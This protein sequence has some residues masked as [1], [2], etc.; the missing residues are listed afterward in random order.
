MVTKRQFV[1]D[2]G[3]IIWLD[4]NPIRGHEQGGR[5]PALV[6]STREYNVIS[7]LAI[8]C[9]ATS[10]VKGYPFEVQFKIKNIDGVILADHIRNVDWIQRHADKVGTVSEAVVTEVQEY[11]KKLVLE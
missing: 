4:F 8:V 6:L 9:P 3:D 10:Q 11:M 2:R 1:P 7:K 5:R